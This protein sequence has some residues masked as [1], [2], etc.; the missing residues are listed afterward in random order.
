[1]YNDSKSC[2]RQN[3]KLS[4][5]FFTYVGVRQGEKISPILFS[6]IPNDLVDFISRG[7]DGL[8]DLQILYIL[9]SI[10]MTLNFTSNFFCCCIRMIQ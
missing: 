4:K 10:T 2:V 8:T 5:Y 7:Y 6:L 3:A 1:M 9:Y